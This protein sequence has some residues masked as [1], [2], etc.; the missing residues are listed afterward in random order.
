VRGLAQGFQVAG[1]VVALAQGDGQVG[2]AAEPAR[3]VRRGGRDR[4]P[5][6]A[7][8]L[9][10][11][12]RVAGALAE[13]VQGVA[14]AVQ[15]VRVG[16]AVRGGA[17]DRLAQQRH[18]L[19]QQ[20]GAL[21]VPSA[22]R[23]LGD[24]GR[25]AQRDAQPGEGLPVPGMCPGDGGQRRPVRLDQLRDVGRVGGQ[26]G[27]LLPCRGEVQ[28]RLLPVRGA[29]RHG[30]HDGAEQVDGLVRCRRVVVVLEDPQQRIRQVVADDGEFLGALRQQA[31]RPALQPLR[32]RHVGRAAGPLGAQEQQR[33]EAVE[34][35]RPVVPA[36]P[37]GHVRSAPQRRDR[38][39]E[40]RAVAVEV[41]AV[42]EHPAEQAEV[43][44]VRR[45]A[46]GQLP[47]DGDRFVE[48]GPVAESRPAHHQDAAQ[49]REVRGVL[50]ATGRRG[51]QRSPADLG[52]GV[53]RAAV[54]G[55]VEPVDQ[56]A[57]VRQ[58]ISRCCVPMRHDRPPYLVLLA[59]NSRGRQGLCASTVPKE[60]AHGTRYAVP[61]V[62]A[63][64]DGTL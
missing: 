19:A 17:A 9:V 15:P 21:D 54:A 8:G 37:H 61:P 28:Q 52:R 39:V 1:L 24:L 27:L 49:T 33:A 6:G 23:A 18:G 36:P 50:A 10:E 57:D 64:L 56:R 55:P 3:P 34:G 7:D 22:V 43:L 41:V 13:P 59:L 4:F 30:R 62:K 20:R 38:L 2:H 26:F 14:E 45:R 58:R 60:A 12:R 16:V 63:S 42:P 48:I 11:K 47:P 5:Q 31:Q 35:G 32:L 51:P 44:F 29:G 25:Q 46:G 53:Q 40:I